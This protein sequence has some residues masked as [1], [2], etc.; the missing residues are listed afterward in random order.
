MN[1]AN[2][3]G[4]RFSF[5]ELRTAAIDL[6]PELGAEVDEDD[7][8]VHMILGALA[9]AT[10]ASLAASDASRARSIVAFVDALLDRRNLDPEI[11][12]AI[13]LTFL[14]P[15]SLAESEAGRRLWAEMPLR[16]RTLLR[17]DGQ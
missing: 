15:E 12:T 9:R 17:A 8:N 6:V 4:D 14:E 1:L 11:E 16:L 10:M 7:Q 13:V 2:D 3:R 5:R